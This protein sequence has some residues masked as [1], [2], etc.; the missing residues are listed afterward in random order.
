MTLYNQNTLDRIQL[1]ETLGIGTSLQFYPF[2]KILWLFKLGITMLI[3]NK[4]DIQ[5]GTEF[6]CFLGHGLYAI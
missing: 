2:H 6:P 5:F 4:D 1:A 3:H